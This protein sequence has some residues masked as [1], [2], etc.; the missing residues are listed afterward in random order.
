[1]NC[2]FP[3][4]DAF[5]VTRQFPGPRLLQALSTGQ[6]RSVGNA[7]FP[8][9]RHVGSAHVN[10]ER[11]HAEQDDHH[12]GGNCQK[13]SGLRI[14]SPR[15]AGGFHSGLFGSIRTSAVDEMQN[16]EAAQPDEMNWRPGM[17]MGTA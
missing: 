6:C 1:M 8:A 12:D 11:R 16:P 7:S 17:K 2:T 3:S 4:L 15:D 13:L 5:R 10:G 9:L 14:T